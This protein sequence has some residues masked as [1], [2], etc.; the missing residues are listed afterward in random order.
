MPWRGCGKSRC[1]EPRLGL[2]EYL[3][4]RNNQEETE[5]EVK[6]LKNPHLVNHF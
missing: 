6:G 3:S 4:P 1:E 2:Q 5:I